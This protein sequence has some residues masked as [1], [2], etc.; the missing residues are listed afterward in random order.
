[1]HP[2]TPPPHFLLNSR[3]AFVFQL[4]FFAAILEIVTISTSFPPFWQS[5]KRC[6]VF[7]PIKETFKLKLGGKSNYFSLL[8]WDDREK[9]G[10]V[11]LF[12]RNPLTRLTGLT[13]TSFDTFWFCFFEVF[14]TVL[15]FSFY[16][17][18]ELERGGNVLTICELIF[19][20]ML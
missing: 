10:D 20:S 13:S 11:N 1:M 2:L 19:F 17:I 18:K 8:K 7:P 14:I 5:W 4:L 16:S 3:V 9:E 6:C 12:F 15:L